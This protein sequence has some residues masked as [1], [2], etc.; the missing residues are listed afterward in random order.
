MKN[1]AFIFPGQGSQTTGMGLDLY[2]NFES[3]KKVYQTA[4]TVLNKS[5]SKICFE[6]PDETLK[7]TINAQ[8][9]IL[10]TSIAALE[11]LKEVSNNRI[12]ATITAGH[13]LG[14]YGAMYCANVM[15]LNTTFTAIQKRADLMD[16][17]TKLK[18]GTMSAVLGLDTD[19]IQQ[20]LNQVQNL[21][22]AQIA[23]YNDPT[24]T[25]I[26]GEEAAI[27]K[28]NE[29]IKEAGARKVIPLAVSGGFHSALMQSASEGF[30]EFVKNLNLNDAL[31]PVVTNVDAKITTAKE[32]FRMKMPQQISSSVYWVQTIQLM[33]KEGVD[34]FIE[35]GNGKVLAGLNRKIC[36]AEIKT[37]N[38]FDSQSLKDTVDGILS[39][40]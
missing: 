13:S 39:L 32:D 1:I 11:A 37:Y 19:T 30:S 34:T 7:Q 31:I 25:V 28:A 24:Q 36:P 20:C 14:E 33:L 17:A 26:T 5:I 23:N 8:S 6:G 18:K 27:L 3:A 12:K 2:N 35:L 22:V 21:G 40:V 38:V 9:A 16:E 4:D 10:A 15:D 29:L